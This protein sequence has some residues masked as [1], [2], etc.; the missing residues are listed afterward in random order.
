MT[1]QLALMNAHGIAMAS[2]RP[3]QPGERTGRDA[4]VQA[5]R[6]QV[7]AAVM[8]SGASCLFGVPMERFAL[9]FER[10][11]AGAPSA[12]AR[13]RSDSRASFG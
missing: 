11:L 10:A 13:P 9:R 8:F 12:G 5:L 3:V 7:P 2:T 4:M 6:G 1:I